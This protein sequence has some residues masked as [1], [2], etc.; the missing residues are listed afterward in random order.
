MGIRTA[1]RKELMNVDKTDL[2][3]ADDV[4]HY[5]NE[6]LPQAKDKLSVI[7]RFNE[8]HSQ[9]QAGLPSQEQHLSYQQHRLFKDILY[10]KKSVESWLSRC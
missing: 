10:P 3:T 4:R 8:H 2:M 9:V 1:L 7:S 6:S 5:L